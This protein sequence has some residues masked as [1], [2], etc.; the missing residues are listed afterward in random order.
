MLSLLYSAPSFPSFTAKS[1]YLDYSKVWTNSE[2]KKL[3]TEPIYISLMKHYVG[4]V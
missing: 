4:F 3:S 1:G 2:E